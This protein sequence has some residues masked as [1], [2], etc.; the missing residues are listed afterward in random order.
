MEEKV[1]FVRVA[2]RQDIKKS[3]VWLIRIAA[4]GVALLFGSLIFMI[5]GVSPLKAYSTIVSFRQGYGY[6]TDSQDYDS[7]SWYS[8]GSCAMF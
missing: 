3:R 7:A 4:F 8:F 5:C 6:Q 2:R 1:P